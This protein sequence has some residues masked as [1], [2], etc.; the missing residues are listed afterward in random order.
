MGTAASDLVSERM[1][2]G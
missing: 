1:D 2:L